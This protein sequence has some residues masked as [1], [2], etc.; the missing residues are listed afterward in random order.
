MERKQRG[1]G[2]IVRLNDRVFWWWLSLHLHWWSLMVL[3]QQLLPYVDGFVFPSVRH[4]R[5]IRRLPRSRRLTYVLVCQI[6]FFNGLDRCPDVSKFST[7]CSGSHIIAFVWSCLVFLPTSALDWFKAV[8]VVTL[9]RLQRV[10]RMSICLV[11]SCTRNFAWNYTGIS[12]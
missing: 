11:C 3:K 8:P 5:I 4:G 6:T 7:W 1:W 9:I 12:C 2:K 10:Q